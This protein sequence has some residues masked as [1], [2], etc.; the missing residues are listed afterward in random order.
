MH[1][2]NFTERSLRKDSK[3]FNGARITAIG[4][5]CKK[6]TNEPQE[7]PASKIIEGLVNLGT[8]VQ[9]CVF[10]TSSLATRARVFTSVGSVEKALSGAGSG[11]FFMGYDLFRGISAEIVKGLM[12]SPVVVGEKNLFAGGKGIAYLGI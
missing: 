10:F 7:S 1:V 3:R 2:I 9:I 4:L 6:D 12:A 5:A 8:N 11:A